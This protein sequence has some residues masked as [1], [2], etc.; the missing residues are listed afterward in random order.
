VTAEALRLD[1]LIVACRD[2][3]RGTRYVEE[4]LGVSLVEGG[5]HPGRGTR[6]VL[7]GLTNGAYL[8]VVG[9]DSTQPEPDAPRWL[10]VDDCEEPRLVSWCVKHS[11]ISEVPAVALSHGI[12]LGSVTSASRARPDGSL[13]SWSFTDP[14]ADRMDGVV[15]F[16]ID[17]GAS[18]HPSDDLDSVASLVSVRV[19]H[20]QADRIEGLFTELGVDAATEEG[21]PPGLVATLNGPNGIVELI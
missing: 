3:E 10:G 13:L 2:V 19:Q 5:R 11:C 4:L 17:W 7:L 16:F 20:P 18:P 12:D 8:E 21:V 14:R 6:N 1:H 15:P 9:V